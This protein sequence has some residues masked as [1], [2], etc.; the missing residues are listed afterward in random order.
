MTLKP[1]EWTKSSYSTNDGP[2]CVEVAWIKS[3]IRIRDS[4]H[5][6][7]P[8]LTVTP[9]AWTAFVTYAGRR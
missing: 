1:S 6:H 9:A 4:K 7:G 2:E 5:P 8:Q 3:S